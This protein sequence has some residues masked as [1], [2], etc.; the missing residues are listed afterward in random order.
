MNQQ[1]AQYNF[2]TFRSCPEKGGRVRLGLPEIELGKGP[3]GKSSL[4]VKKQ[5]V[6]LRMPVAGINEGPQKRHG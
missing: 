1:G 3:A 2:E 6:D 5:P 4:Q